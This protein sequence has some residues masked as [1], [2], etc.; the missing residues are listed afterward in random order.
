MCPKLIFNLLI[1]P[2]GNSSTLKYSGFQTKILF[3]LK[4]SFKNLTELSLSRIIR[5]RGKL[6]K[7]VCIPNR[8]S[9]Y[10]ALGVWEN[11]KPFTFSLSVFK[12]RISISKE[13]LELL[14]ISTKLL[15]RSRR[16]FQKEV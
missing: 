15:Y 9:K 8:V 2:C 10:T 6:T 14:F 4:L 7:K 3:G 12:P 11:I 5:S 16:C 1:V 13:E